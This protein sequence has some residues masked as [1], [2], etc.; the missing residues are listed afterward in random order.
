MLDKA[1]RIADE[2]LFPDADRVD[3]SDRVPA[4]HLDRLAADGFYGLAGRDGVDRPTLGRMVEALAGGCLATTF[5]WIQHHSA[6]RAARDSTRPGISATWYEPL[7]AGRRRAGVSLTGARPGPVLLKAR[8]VSGGYRIDGTAPWVTG[9]DLIDTLYLGA[10]DGGTIMFALL[11][12]VAGPALRVDPLELVAVQASRTVHLSFEDYFVSDERVTGTLPVTDWPALDAANLRLN[13]SLA[14]GVA[15]R[16]CRLIGPGHLDGE[17]DAAR[18]ALDA[19]TPETMPT[20]RARAAE[21]A[22]RA[23]ASLTVHTGS[24][25]VLAGEPAQRLVREATFLL[26]FGSRPAIRA[27]LLDRVGRAPSTDHHAT[28]R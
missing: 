17:L 6:L 16:C 4:G 1:V 18:E 7:R 27:E 10:R 2:I 3:R 23:A 19:G 28:V 26:V 15:A 21:L 13:G 25:G 8:R 14:L 22:L 24:R 11:D 5:V 20:A 9:W 12:A